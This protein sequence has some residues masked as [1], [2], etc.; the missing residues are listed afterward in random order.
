VPA[1]EV[2]TFETV[3]EQGQTVAIGR[4]RRDHLQLVPPRTIRQLRSVFVMQTQPSSVVSKPLSGPSG[5][6]HR[7]T[8]VNLEDAELGLR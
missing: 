6:K 8:R 5:A 7:A 1:P 2:L 3:P 4:V